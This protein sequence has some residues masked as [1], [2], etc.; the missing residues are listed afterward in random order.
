M[1]AETFD[2]PSIVEA[3]KAAGARVA[4][5]AGPPYVIVVTAGTAWG[6]SA[7]EQKVLDDVAGAVGAERPTAVAEMLLPRVVHLSTEKPGRSYRGGP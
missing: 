6:A 2:A 7:A 4:S 5:P 3:W 1:G